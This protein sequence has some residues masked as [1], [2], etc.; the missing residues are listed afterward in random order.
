MSVD[1]SNED[2]QPAYDS[3]IRGS[4]NNWLL[5]KYA[6][7]DKLYLCGLGVG[8][9]IELRNNLD[10]EDVFFGFVRE[11][12]TKGRRSHY[13]LVTFVPEVVSGVRRARALV[14]SRAVGS[15]FKAHEATV[16]FSSISQVTSENVRRKLNL[17]NLPHDTSGTNVAEQA[18]SKRYTEDTLPT[19]TSAERATPISPISPTGRPPIQQSQQRAESPPQQMA[20]SRMQT[21]P[22]KSPRRGSSDRPSSATVLD[23]PPPTPPKPTSPRLKTRPGLPPITTQPTP[24]APQLQNHPEVRAPARRVTSESQAPRFPTERMMSPNVV[25][26]PRSV[27]SSANLRSPPPEPTDDDPG[28]QRRRREFLRSFTRQVELENLKAEEEA[29]Q[30]ARIERERRQKEELMAEQLK[31]E[32]EEAERKQRRAEKARREQ[33]RREAEERER[34]EMEKM[35]AEERQRRLLAA[36][37]AEERRTIVR[38]KSEIAQLQEQERRALKLEAQRAF[39]TQ[40]KKQFIPSP[41]TTGVILDGYVTVQVYESG[42]WK[43]RYFELTPASIRFYKSETDRGGPLS[44]VLMKDVGSLKEWNEGYEE[45]E[46]IAHSFALCFKDDRRPWLFFADTA[47]N[48]VSR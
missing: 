41:G 28:V 19:P 36:R 14:H 38:R 32:Q 26:T 37:R 29:A 25:V 7:R 13:A 10:P 9:V 39:M 44:E 18:I 22:P 31:K 2:I 12:D 1:L 17:E 8:G 24:I 15:L 5:L 47:A 16:Q 48:K 6:T 40:I 23:A 45:L 35:K 27:S 20:P 30:I 33:E 46:T 11:D 3:I 43:R 21:P 34:I 42:V 4:Q